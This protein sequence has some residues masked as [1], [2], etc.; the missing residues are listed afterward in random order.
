M[1]PEVTLIEDDVALVLQRNVALV[2]VSL[3]RMDVFVQRIVSWPRFTTGGAYWLRIIVS[4][5]VPQAFE[6]CPQYNPGA[7]TEIEDVVSPVLHR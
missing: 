7:D 2:E 5:I 1:P 6:S 3:S 4:L